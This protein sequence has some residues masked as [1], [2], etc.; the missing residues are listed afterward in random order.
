MADTVFEDTFHT[1]AIQ[2]VPLETHACLARGDGRRLTVWSSTQ[3]PFGLRTQLAEMLNR[4]QSEIRVLVPPIG[5]AYGSK[6]HAKIE[7]VTVLLALASGRPVRL[8][9]DRAEEFVTITKHE[10]TVTLRTAMTAHGTILGRSATCLFNTGAYAD[11]GPRV[12]QYG[13]YGA[14]GPYRVDNVFV[15]ALAVYTNLPPAGAFR[16]FG[17]PQLGWAHESQMDMIASR[18]GLDPV[19][20]RL[21]NVLRDG[22]RF[23]TG[24]VMA[25]CFYGQLLEE[26]ARR[27]PAHGRAD[28][29]DSSGRL[30]G[31]GY[32]VTT[33]ATIVPSI[34]TATAKLNDDGT[35]SVLSASVDM[36]QG[37]TTALARIAGDALS[38]PP[39]RVEV[40]AI[41]TDS[42]PFDIMTSASRSTFAMGAAVAGAV[43][44]I[45]EQL[46]ALA[47]DQLEI[48][49]ADLQLVG[50]RV[51]P[52]DSPG[53]GRT[54]AQVVRAAAVGN[55]LGRGSYRRF[56]G[57]DPETGQGVGS[58]H[59]SPGVGAAEVAV[60][61][62]TGQVTVLQY[63]AGTYAGR[64]INPVPAELQVE[65]SVAFGMGQALSEELVYESGQLRNGS[66]ADYL[67]CGIRDMPEDLSISILEQSDPPEIHGLGEAALPPVMPA[68]ANAVFAATGVRITD[69]PITPEKVLRG[70]REAGAAVD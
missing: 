26:A 20:L 4:P 12:A 17:F 31:V 48:A 41:D 1:P 29:P 55:L 15:D 28:V 46:L 14:T 49:V 56:G 42:S 11:I 33:K 70:L 67:I 13:A 53:T 59:W 2:H 10:A 19:E 40:T 3:T 66:M 21:R 34:S 44:E 24:E 51:E 54:I 35:L 30:R 39:D 68:I 25:D 63:H 32:A 27:I 52:R 16:G 9:L 22:D 6:G 65:G 5:G 43:A 36:G 57:V 61:P 8:V 18:M 50:G 45:R 37:V 62:A 58:V 47:A 23:G 38:I 7:P 64:V 69:L 60:D